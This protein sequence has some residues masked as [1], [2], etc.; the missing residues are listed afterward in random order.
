MPE[1]FNIRDISRRHL[2]QAGAASAGGLALTWA[3]GNHVHASE[4]GTAFG[5]A[6]A[7]ILLFP[8]GSPPQHETFDPKPDAPTEIQGELKAIDS[9]LPGVQVGELMPKTSRVM[10]R[11]TIVRS[12]SH[13]YPLHGVAYAL[14][15]MPTYTPEIE[16]RPRDPQHWPYIGSIVQYFADQKAG[17]ETLVPRHIG[18]PWPLNSR[19]EDNSLLAGP[20]A[21]FLGQ[22][23]DPVWA[24]FEGKAT[25]IAP[26]LT[27]GQSKEF[28]DPYCGVAPESLFTFR[29][30]GTLPEAMTPDRMQ[31]RQ[32][33][34][35]R[36]DDGSA[37]PANLAARVQAYDQN[38]STAMSLV[39]SDEVRQALDIRR[40]PTSLRERY[41]QTLF[42]Q[43]CLAARRLVEA[44]S[45][46]VTVFWD[47]FG[48]F[49]GGA[50][51]THANHYPR[52]K[53][54]LMPGFDPAYAALITDLEDRGML[55]STLVVWMSEHGRTPQIDSKPKGAGRHHWSR[56][57]SAALAGGGSRRGAVV[58]RSDKNG[59][60]VLETPVSPKDLQ[61]TMYHLLGIS[62]EATVPDRLGRPY[63]IAG[64]GRVRYELIG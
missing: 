21:A 27:D 7:C 46:F 5:Q 26:K 57:Y 32:M 34:L 51:D 16:A 13:P 28:L 30:A 24:D 22:S 50:W 18:L 45:Q 48:L 44:G 8:F 2:L 60:D 17:H 56:V 53:Q 4:A 10:D 37:L 39:L 15:G 63:A 64:E 61:A 35:G 49:G 11:L 38:R 19:V 1:A 3:N 9:S 20:Y 29:G 52:L 55:D 40:E 14:T 31:R 58:G 33:L 42:G 41:G 6:K 59:G 54:E 43:S 12:M 25:T 47:P 36:L 23:Y 62:P